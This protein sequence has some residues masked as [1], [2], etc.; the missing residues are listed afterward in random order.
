[1]SAF[2]IDVQDYPISSKNES[3]RIKIAEIDRCQITAP[4]NTKYKITNIY[5]CE[6]VDTMH[7][8]DIIFQHSDNPTNPSKTLYMQVP[9]KLG[10]VSKSFINNEFTEFIEEVNTNKSFQVNL[11]ELFD[12]FPSKTFFS[13]KNTN[14]YLVKTD[15]VYLNVEKPTT[16]RTVLSSFGTPVSATVTINKKASPLP[17]RISRKTNASNPDSKDPTRTLPI[18]IYE[19]DNKDPKNDTNPDNIHPEIINNLSTYTGLMIFCIVLAF[20]V[21]TLY[22]I[23]IMIPDSKLHIIKTPKVS[24]G[25]GW[26]SLQK[27]WTNIS[28]QFSKTLSR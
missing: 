18:T 21:I 8:F 17:F 20:V 27:T 14:D 11:A 15:V 4:D 9:V 7:T 6:P 26:W 3:G 2:T 16:T 5:L 1:M 19:N 13:A 28:H 23:F 24:G 25:S 12:A 22:I 10:N